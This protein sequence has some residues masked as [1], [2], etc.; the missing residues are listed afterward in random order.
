M[1]MKSG[2]EQA[3]CTLILLAR[4]PERTTLKAE[5]ISERLEVSP[6]YLKKLM[7]MLV[8]AGLVDS[9]P[10]TRG[11]FSLAKKPEEVTLYDIFLAVEGRGGMYRDRG[12]FTSVFACEGQR[13]TGT[14]VLGHVM[15]RAE[16]AWVEVLEQETLASLLQQIR[17]TYSS[18]RLAEMDAWL[19]SQLREEVN[20]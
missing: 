4:L 10:G 18:E 20:E 2:M 12:V 16:K 6:S 3:V 15:R 19:T 1:R 8:Q 17:K 11:G 13:S 5:A 7:R 14:C 9:T